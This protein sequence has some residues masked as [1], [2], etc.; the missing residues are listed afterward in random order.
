MVSGPARPNGAESPKA[1]RGFRVSGEG[2]RA[3]VRC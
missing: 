2:V 3:G 1:L